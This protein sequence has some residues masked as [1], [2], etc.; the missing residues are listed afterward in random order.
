MPSMAARFDPQRTLI[1]A[2]FITTLAGIGV[3]LALVN[4]SPSVY[5]FVP[6]L[7]LIGLGHASGPTP[8]AEISASDTPGRCRRR[9]LGKGCMFATCLR[10]IG[11]V[12]HPTGWTATTRPAGHSERI[13]LAKSP[14]RGWCAP[15]EPVLS[16]GG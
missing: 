7:L 5:A 2:G 8:P 14:S 11:I 10:P 13:E 6:G 3:L 9:R 12:M 1:V 4:G 15:L 16:C